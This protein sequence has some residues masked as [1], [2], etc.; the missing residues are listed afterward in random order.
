MSDIHG[1]AS[2]LTDRH[3]ETIEMGRRFLETLGAGDM[4]ALMELF[5]EDASLEFPFGD[6]EPIQGIDALRRYFGQTGGY[7]KPRGFPVK[8]VY[9]GADPEWVVIE[10]HGD[11]TNV[12]TGEDYTN[13]YIVVIRVTDGKVALF[14]EF[15][16]TAVRQEREG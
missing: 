7:K 1:D 4:D 14:R 2:V 12:K 6:E 10:F 5:H 16:D 13:E 11:L 3:R 15:F 8:R 9:P